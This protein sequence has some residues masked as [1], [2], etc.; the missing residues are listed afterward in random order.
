VGFQHASSELSPD[1][2]T[3]GSPGLGTV[4][5]LPVSAELLLDTSLSDFIARTLQG[6]PM[7]WLRRSE[8][9][10]E[11]FRATVIPVVVAYLRGGRA[12]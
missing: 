1:L 5:H 2:P 9:C 11:H 10:T 6:S 7:Q 3:P 12:L 8:R 4:P